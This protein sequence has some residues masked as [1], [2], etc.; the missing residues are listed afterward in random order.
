MS[1]PYTKLMTAFLGSDQGAAL[2]VCSLAAARRAG[3]A[4]RAVF[5]WSGADAVDVR[6]PTAR[7]D[8]GRSPAIEA[9]G[10]AAL[11]AA[12]P[13][14]R[15]ARGGRHRRHRAPRP[16]LVLPVRRRAGGRRARPGRR[17]RPGAD[18]HRWAALLRRPGE[19]LHDPRHRRHHRQAAGPD[20]GVVRSGQGRP[21]PRT[22]HRA[23]VVHHQARPRHLRP[24]RRPPAG[25]GRVT[26]PTARR[27]STAR[28][29]RSPSRST[30][31]HRP[32]WW[33]P[34]SSATATAPRRRHR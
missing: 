28:R 6:S 11:A 33:R 16:V 30:G 13:G 15:A 25:S 1:E 5:I 8:P 2:V 19:Q 27:S 20:P 22:G 26:P 23:R 4:D 10:Q 32:R 9:A 14:R 21:A 31:P 17:R 34:R 29:S 7:P 3:V 12:D 18:R 24:T